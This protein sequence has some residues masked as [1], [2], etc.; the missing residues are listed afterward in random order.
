[1]PQLW[2]YNAVV[3]DESKVTVHY[4]EF[5]LC[6]KKGRQIQLYKI[7]FIQVLSITKKQWNL[8]LAWFIYKVLTTWYIEKSVLCHTLGGVQYIVINVLH[9]KCIFC[10]QLYFLCGG[11]PYTNTS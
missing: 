6:F 7:I 11:C 3:Y 2:T 10:V 1:M 8:S 4:G 5:G 9:T